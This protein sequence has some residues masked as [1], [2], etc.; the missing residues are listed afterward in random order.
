MLLL[1]LKRHCYLC[2]VHFKGYCGEQLWYQ[3]ANKTSW[4]IH[5]YEHRQSSD[6]TGWK[7]HWWLNSGVKQNLKKNNYIKNI[8][9]IRALAAQ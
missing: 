8:N 5:I 1:F 6:I 3:R 9:D 4:Y 7:M 2:P